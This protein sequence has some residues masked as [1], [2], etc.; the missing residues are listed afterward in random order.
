MTEENTPERR[1]DNLPESV[2]RPSRSDL[3]DNATDYAVSALSGALGLVPFVGSI[4][5]EVVRTIIPNQRQDRIAD[6]VTA[7]GD[8]LA[9]VQRDVLELKMRT[10]EFAD[11]FREA[12]Y[13]AAATPS[14]ERRH[15]LAALLKNSLTH[16]EARY[17]EE[18]KLLSL[19][20]RINDSELI[21]LGYYGTEM[22]G[23]KADEYYF[24]HE[25]IVSAPLFET[26]MSEEET[27]DATMKQ[28]YRDNL[29]RLG[30]IAPRRSG[31]EGITPLGRLLLEYVDG[32]RSE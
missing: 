4:L 5:G 30:L 9:T 28:E 10:Q 17:E 22:V 15:R 24:R 1:S 18:R 23:Q 14:D 26:M 3:D 11:L 6:F 25:D 29:G 2:P 12:A 16:E 27:R 32:P 20:K 13:Q 7:V 19:L 21:I 8:E 31:P